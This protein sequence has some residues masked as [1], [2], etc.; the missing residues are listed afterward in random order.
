MNDI[1]RALLDRKFNAQDVK[2][3]KWAISGEKTPRP[4]GYGNNF[5]K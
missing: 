5:C 4:D 3:A 2:Q 1:R